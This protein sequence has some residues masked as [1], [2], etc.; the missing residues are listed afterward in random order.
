MPE[1]FDVVLC[2]HSFP[3][4]RDQPLAMRQVAANLKPDGELVVLHLSGSE[5]LNAFHRH[6]GGAVGQDFLPGP[7]RWPA[8]LAGAG[9]HAVELVDQPE[10]FLLKARRNGQTAG[11]V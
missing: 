7:E 5:P 3:H 4:F 11:R 9:L 6:V 2:F 1:R 10:L 8:L